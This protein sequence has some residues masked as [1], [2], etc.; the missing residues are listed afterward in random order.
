MFDRLYKST[1]VG[2]QQAADPYGCDYN[3][4]CTPHSPCH[5]FNFLFLH[6][7]NRPVTGNAQYETKAKVAHEFGVVRDAIPRWQSGL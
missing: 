6:G 2:Y 4:S 1:P 5:F 7:Q 3:R